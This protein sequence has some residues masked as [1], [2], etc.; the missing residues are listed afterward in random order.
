[1]AEPDRSLLVRCRTGDRSAWEQLLTRYERLLHAVPRRCGLAADD[2]DDVAQTVCMRLLENLDRIRNEEHLTGWLILT[3]RRESWRLAR[4]R[5]R[6]LPAGPDDFSH[7]GEDETDVP[8]APLPETELLRL[9]EQQ[10]VRR[11]LEDLGERCR[12]LLQWLYQEDPPVPYAEIARRL[13]APVGAI[14]PTRARCL[15]QL[16][17]SLEKLGF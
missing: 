9:E 8:L 14:G 11:A 1:M 13:E 2:A 3:A 16:R 17:R 6:E 15:A 12:R 7:T 4:L 5:G 10:L